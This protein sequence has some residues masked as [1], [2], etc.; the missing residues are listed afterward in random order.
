MTGQSQIS[1]VIS[2]A[3]RALLERRVRATGVKKGY[4]IEDALLHHLQAL[5]SLPTDVIVHPR[6]VVS[7]SSGEQLVKR[8]MAPPRPTKPLRALMRGDGD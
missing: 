2:S 8:M 4:L 3:T 7:R 5:D 1:A 6:L